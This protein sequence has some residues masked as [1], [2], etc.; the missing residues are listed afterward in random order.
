MQ[1]C[2][3]GIRRQLKKMRFSETRD[4]LLEYI[5]PVDTE[6]VSLE[7]LCG[8][9]IA[10]DVAARMN[11]PHYDRSPLD[12]Y[13]V[14]SS[15]TASA[16]EGSPVTLRIVCEI[17]AG[18]TADHILK[19][20]E[21]VKIL[22][23]APIPDG[24][25][26][27]VKYEDT[28]YT[29]D[30][31]T[32]S[33]PLLAGENI[34]RAGEDVKTGD[35]LVGRGTAADTAV[36]GLLASQGIAGAEVY[37]KPNVALISTGNE[38][39]EVGTAL[40]GSRIYNSNRYMLAA[41]MER[42][43][44]CAVY[45]GCAGDDMSSIAGLLS[46]V[47][48]SYDAVVITGGVSAGDYDLVPDALE[49]AGVDIL[50]HGVK[51]KPGM[52]CVYGMYRSKPVIA[53]SGNPASALTNFYCIGRSIL[54]KYSGACDYVPETVQIRMLRDFSK[55]SRGDRILRGTMKVEKG[56]ICMDPS[57]EQGNVIISSMRAADLLAVVP[58]EHGPVAAG[59]VLD[60]FMIR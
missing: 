39:V 60:G 18:D 36:L 54:R 33:Q 14:K 58:M 32:V 30:S 34:I 53:L 6:T 51:M 45:E 22:T 28:L 38:I 44:C 26:A 47:L 31:V 10:E 3:T 41:E 2:R 27:V 12:G 59:D 23:G 42:C 57:P 21:A 48:S 29:A 37:R 1:E 40:T 50:V 56:M 11:V 5:N 46:R 7:E 20:G 8:R 55:K 13:A 16:S 24:A 17:K 35:V 49:R 19:S 52:A 25:D 9:V 15:D 4:M 43:G